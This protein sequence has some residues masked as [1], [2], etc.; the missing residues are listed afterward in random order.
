MSKNTVNSISQLRRPV[1]TQNKKDMQVT[2]YDGQ[3]WQKTA[4]DNDNKLGLI[5]QDLTKFFN[6]N[7]L[8]NHGKISSEKMLSAWLQTKGKNTPTNGKYMST[9]G[10]NSDKAIVIAFKMNELNE[11]IK[12]ACSE[13][14]EGGTDVVQNEQFAIMSA[15]ANWFTI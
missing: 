1:Y 14:S 6:K 2:Y 12:T 9:P 13:N 8:Q 15:L 7:A 10:Y 4:F 5:A 3:K 11:M